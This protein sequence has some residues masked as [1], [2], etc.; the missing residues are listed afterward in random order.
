MHM[1]LQVAKLKNFMRSGVPGARVDGKITCIVDS[2]QRKLEDSSAKLESCHAVI[3]L[4]RKA[5]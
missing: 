3:A 1:V 2:G 5:M 4:S